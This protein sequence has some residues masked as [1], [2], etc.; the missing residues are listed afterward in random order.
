MIRAPFSPGAKVVVFRAQT[1]ANK[2]GNKPLVCRVWSSMTTAQTDQP[3]TQKPLRLWPGV[4]AVVLQWLARFVLPV[5]IPEAALYGDHQKG[6]RTGFT[7]L[8]RYL[9]M[10][11]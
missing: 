3:A 9:C 7:K 11:E 2:I 1:A 10:V 4:L 6:L 5:V 8:S